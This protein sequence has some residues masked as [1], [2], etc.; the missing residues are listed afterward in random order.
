M[1]I[2][3]R[4]KQLLESRNYTQG[5]L[6]SILEISLVALNNIINNKSNPSVALAMKMAKVFNVHVEEIFY[7]ESENVLTSALNSK[8]FDLDHARIEDKEEILK[9]IIYTDVLTIKKYLKAQ[10]EYIT[11]LL[12]FEYEWKPDEEITLY[13]KFD[14]YVNFQ[15]RKIIKEYDKSVVENSEFKFSLEKLLDAVTNY[16]QDLIDKNLKIKI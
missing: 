6:A 2:K 11:Y 7:E 9:D 3:N 15:L 10:Y 14:Y 12:D 4:I 1:A 13:E 8:I 16:N 5:D